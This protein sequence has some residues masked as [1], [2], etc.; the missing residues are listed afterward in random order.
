VTQSYD[1][2]I[3]VRSGIGLPARHYIGI[4]E[5]YEDGLPIQPQ[6]VKR[7]PGAVDTTLAVALNPGDTTMV[8]TSAAGWYSGT[9]S[10]YRQF[11]WWPYTSAMGTTFA[12][13]TYSRNTSVGFPI[14]PSS[15]GTWSAS[16]VVG[17]TITLRSAWPGPS[18]PAGTPVRNSWVCGNYNYC[19]LL[20]APMAAT[21]TT[22]TC[23]LSGIGSDTTAMSGSSW[24]SPFVA[25]T[26]PVVL[27]NYSGTGPGNLVEWRDATFVEVP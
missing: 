23:T 14:Y 18:L 6:F 17:N 15:S 13:Y 10:D 24:N 25:S 9:D 21:W 4:A 5:F 20:F 8:L 1:F 12:P 19:A 2:Q 22:Y 7:S 16:A 27:A 11:T 26:K 3:D